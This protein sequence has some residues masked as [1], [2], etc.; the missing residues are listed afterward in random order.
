MTRDQLSA[1]ITRSDTLSTDG[2]GQLIADAFAWADSFDL[3]ADDS[4]RPLMVWCNA[5]DVVGAMAAID[6]LAFYAD[7]P[8]LRS[9]MEQRPAVDLL[10]DWIDS[11]PNWHAAVERFCASRCREVLVGV[12]GSARDE[13]ELTRR[14]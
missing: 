13:K 3:Q 11:H 4:Y 12:A 7:P 10:R 2:P 9:N 6:D 1:A 8:L 14:M 5:R